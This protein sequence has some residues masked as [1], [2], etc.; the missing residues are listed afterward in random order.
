MDHP[1][2]LQKRHDSCSPPF[3][4]PDDE[5]LIYQNLFKGGTI[6]IYN[7]DQQE[8]PP[9]L[10]IDFSL[11]DAFRVIPLNLRQWFP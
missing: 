3:L 4:V 5:M 8:V 6:W 9:H 11:L 7:R 10:K 1:L 2:R